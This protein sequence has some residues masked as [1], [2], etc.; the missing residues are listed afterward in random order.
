MLLL[1][2]ILPL[3]VIVG[4]LGLSGVA[5]AKATAKAA[6]IAAIALLVGVLVSLVFDFLLVLSSCGR[7]GKRLVRVGDFRVDFGGLRIS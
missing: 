4:L 6:T 2:G 1:E 7:I 3:F 5:A